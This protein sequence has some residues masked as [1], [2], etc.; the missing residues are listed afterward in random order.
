MTRALLLLA[1]TALSFDA[2]LAFDGLRRRAPPVPLL[3][4]KAAAGRAP[5]GFG[6]AKA[7]PPL[8]ITPD[9]ACL[10]RQWD[11]FVAITDLEIS[12][13]SFEVADVFVRNKAKDGP[14]AA[15]AAGARWWRIGKVAADNRVALSAALALQ[16]PL[17]LWTAVHMRQELMAGGGRDAAAALELGFIAPGCLQAG[18]AADSPADDNASYEQDEVALAEFTKKVAAPGSAKLIGFRPDWNPPGFTYKRRESAARRENAARKK[19]KGK[20]GDALS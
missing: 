5:A 8:K 12:G 1:C 4:K 3:A 16:R 13:D 6:A 17:V 10:E 18:G 19:K 14:D 20:L 11:H 7:P 2:A 9:K 15:G